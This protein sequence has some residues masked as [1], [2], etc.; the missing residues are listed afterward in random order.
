MLKICMLGYLS[1]AAAVAAI[2]PPVGSFP[3]H[4]FT[5][6][7]PMRTVMNHRG[8][9]SSDDLSAAAEVPFPRLGFSLLAD[10]ETVRFV[11]F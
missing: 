9:R 1:F 8:P 10:F 6:S 5:V 4:P 3:H 11:I 7:S 2:V